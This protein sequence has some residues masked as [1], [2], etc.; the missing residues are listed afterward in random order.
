MTEELLGPF[1]ELIDPALVAPMVVY[2]CSEENPHTH[3][4]FSVGGG[5][6][7]RFF[8]GVNEGWFAGRG[9]IPAVE[10]IAEHL[11]EIR[12]VSSHQV[13]GSAGAELE[14]IGRIV[15]EG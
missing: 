8:V 11:D 2:L 13:L 15:S 6:F 4:I 9:E 12:D 10:D 7:A 1:A 14:M 3:E 5:R